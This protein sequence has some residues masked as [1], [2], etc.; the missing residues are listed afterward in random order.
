MCLM[1]VI[2][3]R[4]I[5]LTVFPDKTIK[6]SDSNSTDNENQPRGIQAVKNHMMVN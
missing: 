1:R 6:M 3:N 4:K 5:P 2:N